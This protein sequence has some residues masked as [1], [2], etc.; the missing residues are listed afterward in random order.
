MSDDENGFD[1]QQ[2]PIV[3]FPTLKRVL[4]II[5]GLILVI[6]WIGLGIAG[7]AWC[8]WNPM[9]SSVVRS[10]LFCQGPAVLLFYAPIMF[11]LVTVGSLVSFRKQELM[12][13]GF[14]CGVGLFEIILLTALGF[15]IVH[16]IGRYRKR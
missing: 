16:A 14:I 8:N 12:E 2:S 15:L 3:A 9:E 6:L 5:V 1:S 7:T 13:Y 4:G 11:L 10:N